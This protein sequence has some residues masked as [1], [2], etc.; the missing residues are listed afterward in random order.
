MIRYPMIALLVVVSF[1]G[2][3]C[4]T[5]TEGLQQTRAGADETV[6]LAALHSV[7]VAQRAYSLSNGGE[8][9]S[10]EQLVTGGFLDTRF[11]ANKP[12]FKDY[13][14]SLTVTPKASGAPEGSYTCNAD[15]ARPES[16]PGRHFYLDSTSQEIH[17]NTMQ[18][19]TAN[20]Q[21]LHR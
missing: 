3:A 2:L 13:V 12:V 16:R 18:T 8:F 19:A 5:Y 10:F 20:D 11:S 15:P 7:A 21:T 4:Q 9:G 17:V 14:L 1:A 6:V